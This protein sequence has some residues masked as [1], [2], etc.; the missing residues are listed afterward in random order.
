VVIIG[1]FTEK[2]KKRKKIFLIIFLKPDF[3][4][5]YAFTEILERA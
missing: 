3:N 1:F 2:S 5:F 4:S